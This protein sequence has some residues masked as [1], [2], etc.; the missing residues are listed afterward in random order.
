M[1]YFDYQHGLTMTSAKFHEL[2]GSPPRERE[3]M[4]TQKD[5]DL[6]A[7]I[8]VICE[9]IVLKM[10]DHAKEVTGSRNLVLA[11]GVALNCVAN[12]RVLREGPFERI[13][14]QPAAGDSGG[15]IGLCLARLASRA[16]K[17]SGRQAE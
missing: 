12:G 16:E 7:S 15:R 5:M 14:I 3:A 13:W 1:S 17:A 10:A 11:G 4:L 6:A 8:Q 9:E 2:F